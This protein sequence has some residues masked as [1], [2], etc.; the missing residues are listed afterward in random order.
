MATRIVRKP[1]KDMQKFL[2]AGTTGRLL[3]SLER[4]LATEEP[5]FRSQAHLHPSAM[6]KIDWCPRSGYYQLLLDDQGKTPPGE[7]NAL[8]RQNI[9][10]EGHY[11]HDKWQQRFWRQGVLYGLFECSLCRFNPDFKYLEAHTFWATSPTQ[12]LK[13]HPREF[14]KYREVPLGSPAHRI[15]GHSDGWIKDGKPDVMIEIKS[16]GSGTYRFDGQHLI[17]RYGDDFS[18]LWKQTK[19]PFTS[20]INQGQTYLHLAHLQWGD[21]APND[22]VYIYE[23][24]VHQQYKEFVVTYDPTIVEDRFK[25]AADI[26]RRLEQGRGAPDCF[27]GH[28]CDQCKGYAVAT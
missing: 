25:D 5:E 20:H 10:D 8:Q 23:S 22:I 28:A 27:T 2:K 11:I 17:E 16:V 14:L 13:G 24:K 4:F 6:S 12:C 21:D 15:G 18:E 7:I 9:F 1:S 3:G 26:A 19:R